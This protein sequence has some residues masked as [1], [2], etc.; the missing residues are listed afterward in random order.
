MIYDRLKNIS[1]YRGI[2]P[3]LDAA[4]TFLQTTDLRQLAEGKYPILGEKVFAV[5]QRNQLSKADNS[6]LE[7]HKRY[8]DCHLLLAGNECIR[9]GIGNQAEVVPFE[10]EADIGF[11]TCD[12]T[13]DLDLVDDSFAYFFPNEPHQPNNFNQAGEAVTKCLIKVLMAD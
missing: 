9:Y 7:Y 13:Y 2:H 6:L 3:H 10:Q 12:R 5:I 11:V 1:R 8:A 4:I